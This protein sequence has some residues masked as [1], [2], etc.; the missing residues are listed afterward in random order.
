MSQV[1]RRFLR[2][3]RD[4]LDRGVPASAVP[5][6]CD[7]IVAAL[8]TCG[9]I[10]RRPAGR[11]ELLRVRSVEAFGLFVSDRFPLGL[12]DPGDTPADRVSGVRL[13]GDAKAA[14]RGRC[15]GVFI[16]STKPGTSLQSESG[17]L[18]PVAEWTSIGGV[19][20]LTLEASRSWRFSGTVAIVENAE[21]FWQFENEL[22]QADLAVYAAGRL[23]E[24]VLG[25]LASEGMAGCRLVHWGDYDPVGCSEYVRVSNRCPGRTTMHVP[26]RVADLLPVYGKQSLLTDQIDTLSALRGVVVPPEVGQLLAMFDQHRRGLEQEALLL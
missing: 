25:W 21:P 16:R 6:A 12:E 7:G 13:F 17:Q 18:L 26:A 10:E 19:A 1:Q 8:E 2:A 11:G 3:L 14:L 15:E 4:G 9:A 5:A 23:S 20:A 22:P 24:R